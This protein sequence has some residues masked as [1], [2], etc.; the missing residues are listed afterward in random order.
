MNKSPIGLLPAEL[1][2][3]PGYRRVFKSGQLTF[4]FIMPLEGYP[5]SPFPTLGNHVYLAKIADEAGF[6]ALWMRDVPFYDPN[7]AIPAKC[8]T[9]W[10]IWASSLLTPAESLWAQ[11]V[12][13]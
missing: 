12:S 8:S 9:R 1:Q 2:T 4:G 7:L 10:F 11:R 5:N 13:S 3:H 6:S